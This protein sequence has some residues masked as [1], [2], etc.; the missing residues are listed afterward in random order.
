MLFFFG[1]ESNK[2]F[3]ILWPFEAIPNEFSSNIDVS[4]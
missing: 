4:I 3:R 1:F 2:K